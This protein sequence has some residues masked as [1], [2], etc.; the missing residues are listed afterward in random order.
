MPLV[1]TELTDLWHHFTVTPIPN[2]WHSCVYCCGIDCTMSCILICV[3]VCILWCGSCASDCLNEYRAA[4][5]FPVICWQ[6]PSISQEMSLNVVNT[7]CSWSWWIRSCK[8]FKVLCALIVWTC[9]EHKIS[10]MYNSTKGGIYN[11]GQL[12]FVY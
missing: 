3:T 10:S 2:Y 7:N 4:L 5:R 8:S 6:I 12:I 9:L 11:R 1:G